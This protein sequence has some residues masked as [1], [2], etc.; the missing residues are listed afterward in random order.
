MDFKVSILSWRLQ[1]NALTDDSNVNAAIVYHRLPT[2]SDLADLQRIG[3]VGGT[4]FRVLPVVTVTGTREQIIAISKLPAVR[5][6]YGNR[7]LTLNQR[8]RSQGSHRR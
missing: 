3:I 8:T 5:S 6:I 7:T 1:L 2:E 4:R